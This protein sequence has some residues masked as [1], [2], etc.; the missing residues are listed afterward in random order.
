MLTAY[1]LVTLVEF[2]L[3]V[4]RVGLIGLRRGQAS[5]LVAPNRM[6][7]GV[8]GAPAPVPIAGEHYEVEREREW[9]E[10]QRR[11]EPAPD[12][13]EQ[14]PW[15]T[16]EARRLELERVRRQLA[17]NAAARARMDE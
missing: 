4:S 6:R 3:T 13:P 7:V 16:P 5:R 14:P 9:A 2:T 17:E 11:H 1:G 15:G 8:I 12:V 10:L